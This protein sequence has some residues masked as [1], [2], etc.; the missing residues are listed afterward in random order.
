MYSTLYMYMKSVMN[1][2]YNLS[3]KSGNKHVRGIIYQEFY[4]IAIH[5][6]VER[7]QTVTDVELS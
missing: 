3:N 5:V 7:I 2:D 6:Y 4:Q 1:D